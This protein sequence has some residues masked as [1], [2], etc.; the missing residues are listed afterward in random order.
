M[1]ADLEAT[2][3]DRGRVT[4]WRHDVYSQG[5]T[6]RPGYSGVPGLLAG[7]H[8][9]APLDAPPADD[10]PVGAGGGTVR[11]AVPLY[12]VGPRRVRG[13]R[14]LRNAVRSSA[15]RALGAHLNVFAI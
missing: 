8:L 4:S 6:G 10:P 9:A 5:H 2:L 3:D 15:L 13:H 14:L 1:V 7:S 11:N 12:D